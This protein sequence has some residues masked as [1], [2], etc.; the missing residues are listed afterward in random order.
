MGHQ[1]HATGLR[2]A[3]N[4]NWSSKWSTSINNKK[5]YQ[6]LLD[7]DILIKEF[8]KSFCKAH[9]LDLGPVFLKR[10][11]NNTFIFLGLNFETTKKI[12]KELFSKTLKKYI[13]QY[14]ETNV[15]IFITSINNTLYNAQLLSNSIAEN[16]TNRKNYSFIF[17][18][19]LRDLTKNK[20]SETL[21]KNIK[22]IK[23]HLSGRLNGV[24]RARTVKF[25]WG[26]LPLNTLKTK[27]EFAKNTAFTKYGTIGIK[28]WIAF[29][30]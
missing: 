30:K 16:L 4:K 12:E 27:M 24:D 10:S 11:K 2:M 9:N 26:S 20:G 14:T 25:N 29:H 19:I 7:Q 22:G 5:E 17:Q 18:Q 13:E 6:F 15:H 23:I 8:I 28:V 1:N 21:Q 3:I